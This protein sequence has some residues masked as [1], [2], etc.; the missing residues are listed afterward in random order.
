MQHQFV[1]L[2]F[3]SELPYVMILSAYRNKNSL[4][5]FRKKQGDYSKEVLEWREKGNFITKLKMPSKT[6]SIPYS[7]CWVCEKQ[8]K[9][10]C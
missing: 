8:G 7:S 4:S 6:A 10:S 2:V 9:Q 3:F 1:D 5:P